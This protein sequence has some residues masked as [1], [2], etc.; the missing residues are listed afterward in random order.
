M[1]VM[2]MTI[3]T[4]NVQIDFRRIETCKKIEIKRER[5]T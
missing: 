2:G 3:H 5:R 4:D 1:A